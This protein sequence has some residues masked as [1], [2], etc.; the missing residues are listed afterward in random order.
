MVTLGERSNINF[1]FF[2]ALLPKNV[3]TPHPP[4]TKPLQVESGAWPALRPS[5]A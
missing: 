1:N 4:P 5:S 2:P 3:L